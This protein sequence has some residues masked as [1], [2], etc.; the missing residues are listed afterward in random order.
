MRRYGLYGMLFGAFLCAGLHAQEPRVATGDV[1]IRTAGHRIVVMVDTI[2]DKSVAPD[3]LV[4]QWFA[5]ETADAAPPVFAHLANAL[6]VHSP[7]GLRISTETERYELVLAG[8][9]PRGGATFVTGIGLSH[10]NGATTIRIA[11]Q[12]DRR[13][14]VS[15]ECADCGSLDPE[16][17]NAACGS[18]GPGSTSCSVTS[19]NNSCSVTCAAGHSACCNGIA[20]STY[21][22]CVRR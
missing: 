19:G 2:L 22:G 10:N 6:I 13:G 8:T 16:P 1:V 4:D 17:G 15:A 14:N 11:D 5:L 12:L 21:C 3:G 18:G 9:R 7:A 20:G